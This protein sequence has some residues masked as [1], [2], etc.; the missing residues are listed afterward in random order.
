VIGGRAE[1]A[2]LAALDEQGCLRIA[3]DLI[4]V[5][6]ITGEERAAQDLVALMLEEAGLDVDRFEADVAQLKALPRFPGL[7]VA[8]TEAVLVAGL[9]GAKGDRSL[10][11]NG[12]VDVVP[13]GDRNAWHASPCRRTPTQDGSTGGA[14]AT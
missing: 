2:A 7:E 13:P 5:P 4:R 14:P 12:H 3:Q 10:I 9:L 11:L 1:T 6:S 8:R